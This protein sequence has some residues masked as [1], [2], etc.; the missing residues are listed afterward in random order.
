MAV[1]LRLTWWRPPN[2][3]KPVALRIEPFI[4]NIKTLQSKVL[5]VGW[6]VDSVS[7]CCWTGISL[8]VK[9]VHSLRWLW[10]ALVKSAPVQYSTPCQS[11]ES[12]LPSCSDCF[13]HRIISQLCAQQ[14]E[15]EWR[16][17]SGMSNHELHLNL[18]KKKNPI[19]IRIPASFLSS[20]LQCSKRIWQ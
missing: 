6:L 11:G 12:D 18:Q 2:V 7:C 14:P 19:E 15:R 20:C 10:Q 1:F 4:L 8:D 16:R 9:T 13:E 17:L 3:S 5:Q